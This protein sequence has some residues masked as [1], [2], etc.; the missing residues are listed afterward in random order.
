MRSV[1]KAFRTI[2]IGGIVFLLPIGIVLV[3]LGKL[4]AIARQGGAVLTRTLFPNTQHEVLIVLSS[5]LILVAIAFLAGLFARTPLG[6]SAFARLESLVLQRL[7]V[8]TIFR[9][10]IVD[11]AGG[12]ARLGNTGGGQVVLVH[13]DDNSVLGILVDRRADGRNIVYVPGAPSA[14]SGSV[15][16]VEPN[17]IEPTDLTPADVMDG[18]RRLGA[19]LARAQSDAARRS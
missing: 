15:M 5:V 13:L 3:V 4:Y 11:M 2:V 14:L 17:R 7:P 18:M 1:F 19:G 9:Q 8:Y 12:S 10:M 6:I 16:L